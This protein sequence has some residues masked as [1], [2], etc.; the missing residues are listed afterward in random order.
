VTSENRLTGNSAPAN[1]ASGEVAEPDDELFR[2]RLALMTAL[3]ISLESSRKALLSLDVAGIERGTGEQI[4]WIR[5]FDTVFLRS[6]A[7]VPA[8]RF[9]AENVALE[10]ACEPHL[11][12]DLRRS[13]KRVQDA[14]RLQAALLARA[15][16]KLRVIANMLAGASASYGPFPEQK[17]GLLC[18]NRLTSERVDSCRV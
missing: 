2:S 18:T 3:E 13:E 16:R 12:Q 9:S 1:P 7:R 14:L 6:M 5:E 15:A 4:G 17:A 10:P 11:E 8:K